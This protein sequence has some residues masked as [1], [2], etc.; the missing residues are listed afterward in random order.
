[1][2]DTDLEHGHHQGRRLDGLGR[3]VLLLAIHDD[4]EL[5]TEFDAKYGPRFK[6]RS[7]ER[8]H[9][10]KFY[11]LQPEVAGSWSDGTAVDRTFHPPIVSRLTYEFSGWGGDDI[12]TSFPVYIVTDRLRRALESSGLTG[13]EFD[14]VTVTTNEQ[15]DDVGPPAL[16]EW[17]WLRLTGRPRA[18][19]A[20][21][22][23]LG[24]I[25]VSERMLALLREFR[26]DNCDVEPLE[27]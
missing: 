10:M 27:S 20:W 24:D 11:V 21:A 17:A 1:M 13:F 22:G 26:L 6:P 9:Q 2:N 7:K 25:T 16:P 4:H 15:F 12:V 18:S 19:D 3:E 5:Q 8:R 14:V 23:N